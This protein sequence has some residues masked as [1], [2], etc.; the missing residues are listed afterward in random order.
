MWFGRIFWFG[1]FLPF[2][3]ISFHTLITTEFCYVRFLNSIAKASQ[4]IR[5]LNSS[6]DFK[7]VPDGFVSI[8]GIISNSSLEDPAFP[9]FDIEAVL[10][11]RKVEI[12]RPQD[13]DPSI[14]FSPILAGPWIDE[15]E[16][17]WSHPEKRPDFI[18]SSQ[19]FSGDLTLFEMTIDRP[20]MADA[21]FQMARLGKD[22]PKRTFALPNYFS[23]Y[24]SGTYYA[25]V[26][27]DL[28]ERMRKI[29]TGSVFRSKD[30][31][32]ELFIWLFGLFVLR[33]DFNINVMSPVG[34]TPS[35]AFR[36]MQK[37]CEPGDVRIRHYVFAPEAVTVLG[38]KNGNVLK[39]GLINGFRIGAVESGN[40]TLK[41]LF[42]TQTR[43]YFDELFLPRIV[44]IVLTV[45]V[46]FK[47]VHQR[48]RRS[49]VLVVLTWIIGLM[50]AMMWQSGVLN[51][52]HW[53]TAG[54][55]VLPCVGW[56]IIR[57]VE[58][59]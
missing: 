21:V 38:M 18:L 46:V 2:G 44:F 9:G 41:Q 42:Q 26:N 25:S 32:P 50:R 19:N 58:L 4:N 37:H 47:M 27:N 56:C 36:Y 12:C 16:L 31:L 29:Q 30:F 43:A 59:Q 28:V 22:Q 14:S 11:Y 17:S 15:S 23:E 57:R 33:L 3:L 8:H 48:T 45:I 1:I 52:R 6:T 51:V 53:L 54:M 40:K 55:I 7:N 20:L 49:C 39:E 24:Q 35:E 13:M 5:N 10:L 34:M